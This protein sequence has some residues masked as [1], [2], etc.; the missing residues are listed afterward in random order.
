MQGEKMSCPDQECH[1]GKEKLEKCVEKL[2]NE[3]VKKS[4]VRWVVGLCVAVMLSIG[5]FSLNATAKEKDKRAENTKQI[6]VIKN[7]IEH[8][9]DSVKKIEGKQMTPIELLEL[10][11]RAVREAG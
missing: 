10:M 7:D 9:K 4:T 11:K 8:I 3:S 2:K 6:E 1:N 5:G